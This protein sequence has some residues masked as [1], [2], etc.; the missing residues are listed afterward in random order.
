MKAKSKV[1]PILILGSF[2]IFVLYGQIRSYRYEKELKKEGK[3]TIGRI[4]SI[5]RLPKWS[6]MYTSYYI[7]NRRYIYHENDLD[8]EITKTD[9]GKFYEVKYLSHLPKVI[10][11]NYSK[12][13]TDTTAVLKAGFSR[14]EI[15]TG[16][17]TI[18][19]PK[20]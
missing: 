9:I 17:F 1:V 3:T 16:N 6:N 18:D 5:V 13:I 8:A 15:E 7:D 2:L 20:N 19:E 12:Q 14:E 4:D 11:V 10:R